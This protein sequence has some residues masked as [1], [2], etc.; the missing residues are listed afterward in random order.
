MHKLELSQKSTK[1]NSDRAISLHHTSESYFITVRFTNHPLLS[2]FMSL[3]STIAHRGSCL[4]PRR[5]PQTQTLCNV[6]M[7]DAFDG[8]DIRLREK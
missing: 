1:V 3:P 6:E 4:F 7:S 5:E 8:P 2:H